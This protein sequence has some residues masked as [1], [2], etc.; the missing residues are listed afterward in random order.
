VKLNISV[1]HHIRAK[2]QNAAQILCSFHCEVP[3]GALSDQ[4]WA[5]RNSIPHKDTKYETAD[6][7]IDPLYQKGLEA[8]Q[9]LIELGYL[10]KVFLME[11]AYNPFTLLR[12]IQDAEARRL[13]VE[14]ANVRPRYY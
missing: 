9:E 3:Y 11:T 1:K 8:A 13:F 10:D 4:C 12:N 5:H 14:T 2:A 6:D 7:I